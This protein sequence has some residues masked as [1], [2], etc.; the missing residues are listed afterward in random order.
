[1]E[2]PWLGSGAT[3]AGTRSGRGLSARA[4]ATTVPSTVIE[5]LTGGRP[6]P[7]RLGSTAQP[8]MVTGPGDEASQRGAQCG[9]APS[10]P[11]SEPRIGAPPHQAWTAASVQP[12]ARSARWW[13]PAQTSHEAVLR[14]GTQPAAASAL[15]QPSPAPAPSPAAAASGSASSSCSMARDAGGGR[16]DVPYITGSD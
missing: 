14:G 12:A 9:V 10:M 11:S 6:P 7:S 16:L 1:M 13:W 2:K 8:P 5:T 15:S 4:V 3:C